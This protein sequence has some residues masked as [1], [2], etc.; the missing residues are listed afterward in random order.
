MG[1]KG[2]QKP[3]AKTKVGKAYTCMMFIDLGR[4]FLSSGL[5]YLEYI[6]RIRILNNNQTKNR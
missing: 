6:S 1:A 5:K 3:C 4:W 2:L